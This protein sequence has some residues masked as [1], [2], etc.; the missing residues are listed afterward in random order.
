MRQT[1]IALAAVASLTA[2]AFAQPPQNAKPLSE[3][4]AGIEARGDVAYFDEVEWDDDGYWEIKY[5]RI[6]GGKVEIDVDP[7]SGEAR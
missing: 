4:L 6:G 2:T 7:V 1:L 5:Y 3:I